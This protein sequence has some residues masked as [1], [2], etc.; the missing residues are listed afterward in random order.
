M[1]ARHTRWTR[2]YGGSGW[3]LR[4]MLASL[5]LVTYII[6]TL[7]LTSLWDSEVWW[8]SIAVWFVGAVVFHDLVLFPVYALADRILTRRLGSSGGPHPGV[9]SVPLI[10]YLRVPTM[11]AAFTF[12]MFFPGI[13]QQGSESF[14]AATGLTQAPFLQR[15]LLLVGASFLIS[16]LSYT[17]VVLRNSRRS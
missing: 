12:L 8:Q 10:N 4:L 16:G 5:A 15:W 3:H 9:R 7:G 13:L 6:A 14:A 17:A 2:A 1:A 11:V